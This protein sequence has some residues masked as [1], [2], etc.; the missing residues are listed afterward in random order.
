MTI[1]SE[2]NIRENLYRNI[3]TMVSHDLKTPLSCIIGSLEITRRSKD[4]LTPEKKEI[5]LNTALH[6]AYRLNGF[7]TN[8]LDMAKFEKGIVIPVIQSY[9]LKSLILDCL[10]TMEMRLEDCHVEIKSPES[11]VTLMT[12]YVLLSRA[13]SMLLDNSAK[14]C[15]DNS[16]IEIAYE[17]NG[18]QVIISVKD[19]GPGIPESQLEEIF[20]KYSRISRRD[21]QVAG[22]GLGLPICREIMHLLGGEVNA[23]NRTDGKGAIFTLAFTG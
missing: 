1:S 8:I 14:Y 12:D 5:L 16:A 17:R 10:K 15:A 11:P 19:N 18:D 13:I 7:I 2:K 4:Q 9:E 22:T 21:Y 23:A 20:S 6:E 3:L